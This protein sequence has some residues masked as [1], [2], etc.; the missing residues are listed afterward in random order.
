M[1]NHTTALADPIGW[2][3]VAATFGAVLLAWALAERSH[4]KREASIAERIERENA[5]V[6]SVLYGRI[7]DT[8]IRVQNES[9]AL[10]DRAVAREP[11]GFIGLESGAWA[12]AGPILHLR[13]EHDILQIEIGDYFEQ[14]SALASLARRYDALA[15][16]YPAKIPAGQRTKAQENIAR[17]GDEIATQVDALQDLGNRLLGRIA[18]LPNPDES[19]VSRRAP[20]T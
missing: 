7:H 17:Y 11:A 10:R 14:A 20:T 9:K 3:Q 18:D 1:A 2:F 5:Q 15:S 16:G 12:Q 6:S 8:L 4:R 13:D 19:S